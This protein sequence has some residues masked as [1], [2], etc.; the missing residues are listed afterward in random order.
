MLKKTINV[1]FNSNFK[2]NGST[3]DDAKYYI[4]WSAI[5]KNDDQ[6]YSVIWSYTS[7]QSNFKDRTMQLL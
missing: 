1:K 4:D 3:N 6:H 2:L 5:L 7:Q